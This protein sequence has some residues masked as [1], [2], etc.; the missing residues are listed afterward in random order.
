MRRA[1]LGIGAIVDGDHP[2]GVLNESAI[3]ALG[4]DRPYLEHEVHRQMQEVRRRQT[5]YRCG[6]PPLAIADH[7]AIVVDDG[8]A[9][10][11]TMRAALRGVR[12]SDPRRLV[13]AVPVAAPDA[14]ATLAPEVDDVVCL[15][16]P[17]ISAR[18]ASSIATSVRLRT[19][20]SCVS[21]TRR[22]TPRRAR[23]RERASEETRG[24]R[25]S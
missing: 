17:R 13:L 14:L 25:V 23:A 22:D 7:T 16:A 11:S 6:R 4:V 10:G 3:A 2:E 12:R 15:T 9:T 24:A 19:R 21:S 8:L 20:R 18:S 5:A 1:E